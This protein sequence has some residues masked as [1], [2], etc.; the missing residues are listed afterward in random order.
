MLTLFSDSFSQSGQESF[1]LNILESKRDG[2]FIEI[3]AYHS[4]ELSNTYLLEKNFGWN[5]LAFEIERKR[6]KEYNAN[7][8]SKCLVADATTFNYLKCFKEMNAP[9]HMDYLQVDIEPARQ[10]LAAL[11]SLPLSE[12]TF[13]VITFE[14]D[15]YADPKNSAIQE[16]AFQLLNGFGYVRVAKNVKNNGFSYEDWYINPEYLSEKFSGF[17]LPDET[18]WREFFK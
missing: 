7:R 9:S 16:D 10:S 1:V 2:F 5:G 4:S 18:E 15:L 11:K 6:G 8:T 17:T 14:H 13:R 12:Y 3:G